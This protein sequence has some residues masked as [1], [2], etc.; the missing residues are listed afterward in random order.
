[1]KLYVRSVSGV[2]VRLYLKIKIDGMSEWINTGLSVHTRDWERT[3]TA[4]ADGKN[5]QSETKVA[6]LMQRLGYTR[7]LQ[8]IENGLR[9]L[10][11]K[12]ALTRETARE[13]VETVT[14]SDLRD[15]QEKMRERAQRAEEEKRKDVRAFIE[16]YTERMTNG[17]MT[18][19]GRPY[20]RNTIENIRKFR[21]VFRRFAERERI[22]MWDNLERRHIDRFISFAGEAYMKSSVSLFVGIFRQMAGYAVEEGLRSRPIEGLFRRAGARE[23]EKRAAVYLTARELDAMYD[24]PLT[25]KRERVRDLFLIGCFTGQRFSDYNGIDSS[26]M[27]TTAKGTRVIRLTQKK[28][29]KRVVIPVLDSRLVTLLEKYGYNVPGM[30]ESC[31][32]RGIKRI[33]EMLSGSVP[34]LAEDV[35]TMLTAKE[36]RMESEGRA[37]FRR[38]VRGRTVRRKWE[39][40]TSHTA[41]RTCVTLMH[42]SGRYTVPQMMSVSGHVTTESFFKY[43]RQSAD[44]DADNI[45][46]IAEDGLF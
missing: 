10:R 24:L 45:A 33:G 31:L 19:G 34:S 1:M 28:T 27:G 23:G 32:N 8:D 41:R 43:L 12:G 38:D 25:G 44:D 30:S 42:L 5:V 2:V 18:R 14:L 21:R 16:D 46:G 11:G 4:A 37:A 20:S 26:C 29:G 13:L 3:F 40:I 22:G 15:M 36:R 35:V 39:L 7:T 6:N 17:G 9:A